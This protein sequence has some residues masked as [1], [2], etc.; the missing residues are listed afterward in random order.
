MKHVKIVESNVEAKEAV[1]ELLNQ[2]F[3]RD[4][5]YL[6]AHDKDYS[7][8]ITYVTGTG[9]IGTSEQGVFDSLANVFRSRGDELRSKFE[10][11]GLSDIEA[12]RLEEEL[13]R[14]RIVVVATNV[15]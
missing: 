5:V 4:E 8:D 9:E 6:L 2:G 7:E 14:G 10:S 15:A 13:D 11:L 1:E 12:S 3:T